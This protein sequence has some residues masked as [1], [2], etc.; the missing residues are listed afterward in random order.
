MLEMNDPAANLETNSEPIGDDSDD[1]ITEPRDFGE[2]LH[3]CNI[4]IGDVTHPANE[5]ICF[6]EIVANRLNKIRLC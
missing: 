3:G 5:E 4:P 2:Y 6:L 1:E